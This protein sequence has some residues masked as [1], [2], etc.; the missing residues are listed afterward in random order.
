MELQELRKRLEEEKAAE[1]EAGQKRAT[2][3]EEERERIRRE[4]QDE[5]AARTGDL[6]SESR[7]R[8]ELEAER[9]RLESLRQQLEEEKDAES[10][11]KKRLEEQNAA[12]VSR[13]SDIEKARGE[14]QDELVRLGE[15]GA[16]R[17]A[18]LEGDRARLEAE[19]S[20]R[21]REAADLKAQNDRLMEELAAARARSDDAE[22]RS[23]GVLDAMSRLEAEV[24]RLREDGPRESSVTHTHSH[25]LAPGLAHG[26]TTD[27]AAVPSSSEHPS[28]ALAVLEERVAALSDALE[29]KRTKKRIYK[30]K[31]AEASRDSEARLK[32]LNEELNRALQER[33]DA[34]TELKQLRGTKARCLAL[35][36]ALKRA[37]AEYGTLLE[38]IA[39]LR[40][41]DTLRRRLDQIGLVLGV[42]EAEEA[43]DALAGA[44]EE[45]ER[46]AHELREAR[47]DVSRLRV[48]LAEATSSAH[49][50]ALRHH[51]VATRDVAVGT[52]PKDRPIEDS[53]VLRDRAS[54]ANVEVGDPP[55]A[56]LGA[57]D[58]RAIAGWNA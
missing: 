5:L 42:S 28:A 20:Q 35:E 47:E 56:R 41:A 22:R 57:S 12:E 43:L 55:A 53:K 40:T 33:Y 44:L 48:E 15:S 2:E 25:V 1:H 39:R 21:A 34:V 51:A 13:L 8:T 18:S 38:E 19:S 29:R 6:E 31:L 30:A 32:A 37:E 17:E 23:D 52:S 46:I 49:E 16:R 9:E 27:A 50:M 10:R 3:L 4:L 36:G 11:E 24:R 7:R 45:R 54:Q 58:R 14:L 26:S